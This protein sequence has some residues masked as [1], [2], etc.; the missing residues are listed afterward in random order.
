MADYKKIIKKLPISFLRGDISVAFPLLSHCC[1]ALGTPFG[2]P[3]LHVHHAHLNPSMAVLDPEDGVDGQFIEVS[4]RG[5]LWSSLNWLSAKILAEV[6]PV[7][8]AR[9]RC[10]GVCLRCAILCPRSS[11]YSGFRTGCARISRISKI[12]PYTRRAFSF[13][14]DRASYHRP[15]SRLISAL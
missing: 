1:A 3:P 10:W 13:S 15:M 9:F 12:S 6:R 8:L 4:Q 2:F 7:P 11:I 5:V 14:P